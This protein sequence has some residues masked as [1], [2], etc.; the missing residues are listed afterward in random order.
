M[1]RLLTG[2]GLGVAAGLG[3][4][5]LL[6][7]ALRA[8]FTGDVTRLNA[9]DPS[10]LL[11]AYAD[12]AVLHFPQGEHR[13]AGPWRGKPAIERFL[14]TFVASRIQGRLREIAVSGPPWALTIWARFD[15]HADAADGTR[16]YENRA[17]LVLRTRWGRVVDHEDFFADTERIAAFDRALA[18]REI[19]AL[20]PAP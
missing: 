11:T 1:G 18:E 12:D 16:L 2:I 5:A 19:S 10:S 13:F 8:K 7:V 3:A 15:D 17:V 14:R 9:G 4:R 6:P 20:Q